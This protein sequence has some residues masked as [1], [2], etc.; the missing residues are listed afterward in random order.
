MTLAI[1]LFVTLMSL[2]ASRWMFGRWLN[3]VGLY[4]GIWGGSLALFELRLINYYPLETETWVL[5]IDAWMTFLLG[6]CTIVVCH[7]MF[8]AN[9][10]DRLPAAGRYLRV[11]GREEG[12]LLRALWVLNAIA[13][14]AA[15]Q[16]WYI[17]VTKFGSVAKVLLLGNLL[18]SFRVSEGL[19]GT[20]P[21]LSSFALIGALLA[22]V[23]TAVVGRIRL[24]ALLPMVAVILI[25][26]AAM[27]RAKLIM[28]AILFSAG[29]F[30][31][32]RRKEFPGESF[33]KHRLKRILSLALA[34]VLLALGG[35]FVRS[36][37]GANENVPYAS[38]ALTA[39]RG[40]SFLT[41]T[42]VLYLTVHNGVFNQYLK[43]DEEHTP[44]GS[45]T[46]APAYR[47]LSKMGFD[48]GIPIYQRFYKTP[49][50][51][52][53]GTFLRELHADFG[54]PG[55]LVF[56]YILGLTGAWFWFRMVKSMSYTDIVIVAYLHVIIAMSIFYVATRSGDILLSFAVSLFCARWLDRRL[57]T[58]DG[59]AI[60]A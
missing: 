29:F 26:V 44:V 55:V 4:A 39:L 33:K 2:L 58:G 23:Y 48:T 36:T 8:S 57:R 41:P 49:T 45:N 53:T 34:I 9:T 40:A 46:F 60:P 18:Y 31:F 10:E 12:Y 43:R 22:G 11:S 20:V 50:T 7:A 24:V 54:V 5:I 19:P 42:V 52:N 32:R 1:I 27:G 47:V 51:A 16:H 14:G 35:E 38:S 25:E 13:L 30:F 28:A 37:R 17:V 3:P 6:A 15:V 56:P 59:G 21:Y